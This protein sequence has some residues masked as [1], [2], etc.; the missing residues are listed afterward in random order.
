MSSAEIRDIKNTFSDLADSGLKTSFLKA[1]AWGYSA[2][3]PSKRIIN[4]YTSGELAGQFGYDK[5]ITRREAIL[6]IWRYAGR[7]AAA[8]NDLFRSFTDVIGEYK[9]TSDSYKSIMWAAATGIS[10]GY[11]N[12]T[13]LLTENGLTAPCYGCKLECL[14]E[15]MI[16]FLNRYDAKF[17]N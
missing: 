12:Q 3:D 17:G 2:K 7:P 5:T 16:V 15:D 10:N 1:I 11:R 8:E 13:D 4:G 9:P 14:R 6:M